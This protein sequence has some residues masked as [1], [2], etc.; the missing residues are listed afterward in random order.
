MANFYLLRRRVW[1]SVFSR[2]KSI[3]LK[4]ATSRNVVEPVK[5]RRNALFCNLQDSQMCFGEMR[6]PLHR[7]ATAEAKEKVVAF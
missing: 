7:P 5:Q 6:R 2:H 3:R 1:L 4:I